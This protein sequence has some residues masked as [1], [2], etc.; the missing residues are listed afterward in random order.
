MKF[1]PLMILCL[2]ILFIAGSLMPGEGVVE[3]TELHSTEKVEHQGV[4]SGGQEQRDNGLLTPLED[5][6]TPPAEEVTLPPQEDG[7]SIEL[8]PEVDLLDP[9]LT[10]LPTSDQDS[11]VTDNVLDLI[12]GEV[13]T[14]AVT[15]TE[16][17][18]APGE[19]IQVTNTYSSQYSIITDAAS[20]NNMRYDYVS[21]NAD[22]KKT[23][24]DMETYSS[25]P[26]PGKGG[27]SIITN[28]YSESF[29]ASFNPAYISY[30][31][32]S[33]P[34]LL[35]KTL[36]RGES[37][38]LISISS[39]TTAIAIMSDS[40]SNPDGRYDYA[41]FT[42]EGKLDS[43]DM[44]SKA[45][46]TLTSSEE[47]IITG[48]SDSPV[49][50]G[51]PYTEFIGEDTDE[52]AYETATLQQG[53][54]YEFTNLGTATDSIETD[55]TTVDKFDYVIYLPDGTE[56]SNGKNT[57]NKPSVGAGKRVVMTLLTDSPVRVGALYRTFVGR[58]VTDEAFS[59]VTLM[60]GE[61][62]L[63]TNNG[64]KPNLVYHDAKSVKGKFDYTV[65]KSDGSYYSKG[66]N[67]TNTP[68]IPS[69]GYVYMTVASPT[70]IT[71]SYTDDFSGEESDEPSHY[72][73]TLHRGESIEFTNISELQRYMDSDATTNNRFDYVQYNAN[74]TERSKKSD[75]Y[76]DPIVSSGIRIV[77]TAVSDLPVTVG[78]PYRLFSWNGK[79]EEAFTKQQIQV[80]ESYV[81]QNSGSKSITIQNDATKVNGTFDYAK[82]DAEGIVKGSG[83]N[84]RSN[85]V[86]IPAYGYTIVTGQ[87]GGATTFRYTEPVTAESFSHPAMLRVTLNQ[88]ES[89]NFN[90]ITEDQR[91]LH[92][93]ESASG[94]LGYSFVIT[95]PD[96]SISRQGINKHTYTYIMGGYS[97]HITNDDM[98][99]ITFL[100]VYTSFVSSSD[101]N[102]NLVSVTLNQNDSYMFRNDTSKSLTIASDATSSNNGEYDYVAY[103]AEGETTKAEL[104]HQGDLTIS[105]GN[106]IVVTVNSIQS[107]TF[108]Y[109]KQMTGEPQADPAFIKKTLESQQSGAFINI[110]LGKDQ[111]VTNAVLG[112]NRYYDYKIVN[113]DG[114]LYKEGSQTDIEYLVPEGAEITV[115]VTSTNPV[116]VGAPFKHFKETDPLEIAFEKL[117]EN[118]PA[119][120]VKEIGQNGYYLL[121]ATQAGSYRIAT[122]KDDMSGSTVISV[123]TDPKLQNLLI[124]SEDVEQTYG[125]DYVIIEV[126]LQAGQSYYIK[127]NDSSDIPLDV[128]LAAA[129][130]NMKPTSDYEYSRAGRLNKI[131]YPTGDMMI[132][133]YDANGNLESTTKRIYPFQ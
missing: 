9:S 8:D 60:P 133:T 108:R 75:T 5:E 23:F 110:S 114:T 119:K 44:N 43:S 28:D 115:K 42:S 107:V 30:S 25:I 124:T 27:Y 128:Y 54:S 130:L 95:K 74:G 122:K 76:I 116:T 93:I 86:S 120:V 10:E 85:I 24:D 58:S 59:K 52:P 99:P 71:F 88:G 11:E 78:V 40:T 101:D 68:S 105:S 91:T 57:S 3:G 39:S 45:H 4:D 32:S 127:L 113:A 90:N 46:P 19:S 7:S 125:A 18:I 69:S 12:Q 102:S 66:F 17:I 73:V 48:A 89:Y 100:V 104:N 118:D 103:A 92:V 14:L 13:S 56:S 132:Y 6:L 41:I 97:A 47:M 64:S 109:A 80:G 2:V 1:K 87:S 112:A 96:G 65:Y 82:Y 94:G 61:T 106:T 79:E 35:K 51:V 21:Y 84:Y 117:I 121:K 15:K 34:A 63:F 33:V 83:Y 98:N 62:Y 126:E 70:A 55:G 31:Y 131:I 129:V 16:L 50:I 22:G 36:A 77:V 72:R 37:S 123:Y 111:L 38:Q 20:K 49:T 67:S 26:V 29:T 81:F 53:Q